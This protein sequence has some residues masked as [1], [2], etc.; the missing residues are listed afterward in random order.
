MEQWRLLDTGVRSAFENMAIDEALLEAKARFNTPATFRF[1]QFS[2][3]AVLVGLHQNVEQEVRV[4]FCKKNKIDINRR[5]TGGGTI[6]FDTSQLGWEIIINKSHAIIPKKIEE[7]YEVMCRGTIAGLKK[8]KVIAEFRPKNDIEVEG[9]KISGTGGVEENG[10]MLFQGTLLTD[11]DV[12]TM[13]R[14]LRVP[15]E[16][17]QYKKL[18]SMRE[19]VT[20]LREQLGRVLPLPEIKKALIEG[21]QETFYIELVEEGLTDEEKKLFQEKISKFQSKDWIYNL[22]RPI[23]ARQT[24]TARHKTKGG[25]I[26]V[27]LILDKK[28]GQIQSS[29]IT[30]DFTVYPKRTIFDLE[31]A[32]KG[33]YIKDINQ[34]ILNF[35]KRKKPVIPGV[36]PQDFITTIDKALAKLKYREFGLTFEEANNVYTVVKPFEEISTIK[37]LLLPY[38]SK[39]TTCE[40]RHTKECTIC[41]QCS[42]SEAMKLAQEFDLEPIHITS[43]EDLESTLLTLKQAGFSAFIGSCCEAFYIKHLEDFEKIGLPGILINI[44]SKTCYELGK[45]REAYTGQFESQTHLKMN[46]LRTVVEQV[47]KHLKEK[48][49][50]FEK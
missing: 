32:L 12:E 29:L 44:D 45:Q 1:L 46:I 19:R 9:R 3:N 33:C 28:T 47:N 2:P 50:H 49:E 4:K 16:K 13:L 36:V 10:A 31:T 7:V 17:L 37:H 18:S 25:L 5:I 20:C 21:M 15:I 35:F 38:C 48:K 40:Y 41:G 24:L 11:F 39:L 30:G 22:R 6:Y 8:L 34:Q 23:I 14:A 43:Y 42:I 27:T 26:R